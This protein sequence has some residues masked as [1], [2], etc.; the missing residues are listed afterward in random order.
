MFKTVLVANRGEIAARIVAT[1]HRLGRESVA[2]YSDP[3]RFTAPVLAATKAIGLRGSSSAQTYL[4]IDA[5]VEAAIASGADAVHPGYGFLSE[6]VE[7]AERLAR[8]EVAFIGPRAEHLRAFGL[9]HTARELAA[10][11]GLPLLPGSD[12]LDDPDAALREASRVGYP[13]MLKS[14]AGGGGIGMQRC[15]SASELAAKFAT[16]SRLGAGN[17]GDGRVY[18]EKYVARA[19]HIEVQIFGDGRGGV[20]ALGERDCTLQ[21]RH[22]KVLEET[23]APQIS[24]QTREALHAA[25]VRL[26]ESVAYESAGTVEFIYDATTADFYFLEVNTRLQVEHGVTEEI[27][28]VDLVEWMIR[29]AEG[30]FTLPSPADLQATG[31]A[32][33]VRVYAEDPSRAYRPSAGFLTDVHFP[34]NV[35]VDTWIATGTD[36]TPNYD[37][38]L[39]KI[40]AHGVT[41][42]AAM[43]TLRAALAECTIWGI[44][45]NLAY[46][47]ALL[48]LDALRDAVMTTE[49]LGIFAFASPTIEVLKAGVQS[50]LQ[51]LPGRLGYWHVGVPPSGPMDARS[52]RIVNALAGNAETT[53]ALEMTLAGATLKFAIATEIVFGGARMSATLDGEPI[54]PWT[55]VAV[56]AGGEVAFGTI[57][58]PG[59]RTYLAV[60]GGFDGP[61]FLGSRAT[62]A[63]G[64]FGGHATGVLK[65]GDVLRIGQAPDT[66]GRALEGYELPVLTNAWEIGVLDGPHGAPDFFT[67]DDIATLYAA[68]YEVHFN[69]SRTGVR[70][71]GPK[72]AWAR[73][74]GG[75]A[76]LHPS[77]IHDTAYAIG[78]LDFTG[79][80]PIVLGPD[81]PSLGGFVCPVVIANTE[82]WKTGQL[83]PGDRVRFVPHASPRVPAVHT[84]L[85]ARAGDVDV[86]YRIA[87][88]DNLLVEYGPM[89]LDIAL[90]LR[91]QLLMDAVAGARL[92]GVIDLT[93]GIRSLQIHYAS[94]V[95][96]RSRLVEIL[97][98]IER[99]LPAIDDV[100]IP[101]RIVHLPLSWNDSA[102]QLAMR[103][104]QEL[105]RP[106]APWCPSNI[107]FIRRINGLGSIE[108][109]KRIVFDASYLVLGLGDVYLGAPVATPLDPRHRLVTTKYNPA[110]TWTPENAV[111]I[112]GAYL[113]IYGM[114]GPGGYQLVGRTIQVWNSWH[115]TA[116]FE[117][118]SPWLLRFF[119]RI[120]F[121]PVSP[122]ELLAAR[123]AF[124]RG[125]YPVRIEEQTFRYREYRAFLADNA[126]EIARF[127]QMQ[128]AAFE[129]ERLDWARQGL[130]TYVAEDSV[131]ARDDVGEIFAD[132]RSGIES[133][134]PGNVWKI[135][136]T[137][138]QVVARGEPLVILESMKMEFEITAPHAGIVGEVRC[139]A[140]KPVAAGQTLIVLDA[141]SAA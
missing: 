64:G 15:A 119:D 115:S 28:G 63:L 62:F 34:T 54:A 71:I 69:S 45:T 66:N 102:A 48:E 140:G 53:C 94:D 43:A 112:G 127:R 92:P 25:A 44:E 70:L 111:G 3:D 98:R 75:E 14:T 113:C 19:R 130:D 82:L 55:R 128:R 36:V 139:V 31:H 39:A 76:G 126:A 121:F 68:T 11:A 60:R 29:Q 67:G 95:L 123:E 109:V 106:N 35:R 41:R 2:V 79:D 1:V 117:P 116:S 72:P 107:E 133:P 77:N 104:Y 40:I 49:T 89:V 86:A 26:A 141:S 114:E 9:K 51:E 129:T 27:Y 101:S 22:Q 46:L 38:L 56:P 87:G 100:E 13:V 78:A 83:R 124:P 120:R 135:L 97:T 7:F 105:V 23:P 90:R 74:D 103:K 138:G 33:E 84:R 52:F 91:V 136:A 21:R 8:A 16:V 59:N 137:P 6:N 12:L 17:F 20:L 81:G 65:T 24:Q 125:G 80:V 93:P 85:D 122:D 58:G 30:D 99:D 5:I 47:E 118:G 10:R 88:E 134:V 61:S 4:N 42:A 96:A 37:P 32:V 50:S 18:L 57:A 73:R 110:R 108:D 132:G 131:E